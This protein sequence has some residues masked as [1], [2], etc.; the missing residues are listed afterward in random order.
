[1]STLSN[2]LSQLKGE[3]GGGSSGQNRPRTVDPAVARLKAERKMEREKQALKEAQ[4]A[5]EARERRRISHAT[6]IGLRPT[7]KAPKINSQRPPLSTSRSRPTPPPSARQ[8][9]ET[10]SCKPTKPLNFGDLMKKAETIDS[11]Q[12]AIAN[13]VVVTP[14]KTNEVPRKRIVR[15]QPQDNLEASQRASKKPAQLYQEGGSQ[16]SRTAPRQ[17][18]TR[19]IQKSLK[20]N[21]ARRSKPPVAMVPPPIAKPSAKLAAKLAARR[22]KNASKAQ[23]YDS[24]VE[25]DLDGFIDDDE[26]DENQYNDQGYDRNEIWS[27]FSRNGKRRY[28]YDD[29]ESDDM[30]ANLEDIEREERM[31]LKSAVLEDKR[32]LER[33]QRLKKEKWQR[34]NQL[35]K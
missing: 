34:L 12:F 24:D 31:A 8:K 6:Q 32:E 17:T 26:D 30:E 7:S 22:K 13:K 1:M 27:L 29:D 20:D 10:K 33:E 15:S 19:D 5:Q 35:K 18:S 16:I 25:S 3:G 9:V 28:D 23:R 4:Q 14:K 2:L 21:H 11:S